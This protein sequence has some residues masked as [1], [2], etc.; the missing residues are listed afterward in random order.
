VGGSPI[1]FPYT[2]N[3]PIGQQSFSFEVVANNDNLIEI[4]EKLDFNIYDLVNCLPG[5]ITGSTVS[6]FDTTPRPRALLNFGEGYANRVPFTGTQYTTTFGTP[7]ANG[8]YGNAP[9]ILR[10]GHFFDGQNNEFYQLD[11]FNLSIKNNSTTATILAVNPALGVANEEFWAPGQIKNFAVTVPYSSNSTT[12]RVDIDFTGLL[13]IEIGRTI[14]VDGFDFL[15]VPDS[16]TG[17]APPDPNDPNY[18]TPAKYFFALVNGG[19]HDVYAA[20]GIDK[21]FTAILSG[22]KV[23]LN[24]ISRATPLSTITTNNGL[25]SGFTIFATATTINPYTYQTQTPIEIELIGNDLNY[26]VCNYEITISKPGFNDLVINTTVQAFLTP[27]TYYLSCGLKQVLRNFDDV[28]GESSPILY[29]ESI[30][31]SYSDLIT[32]PDRKSTRL[33]SSH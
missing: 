17:Y 11:K 15:Y 8:G 31:T 29:N 28:D 3:V 20:R 10:N 6:I 23:I 7:L 19:V 22:E 26:S 16:G 18:G 1:T 4:T 33:N 2:V 30:N 9:S 27:A 25:V 5:D 21:P 32:S 14:I 24:A 12:A 13:D